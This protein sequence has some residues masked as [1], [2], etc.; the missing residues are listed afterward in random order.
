MMILSPVFH[1]E[2]GVAGRGV[3]LVAGHFGL[4]D[5]ADKR[6]LRLRRKLVFTQAT[7]VLGRT[8]VAW[9]AGTRWPT[10][11]IFAKPLD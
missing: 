9:V 7:P 3:K 2:N 1:V 5:L 6:V 11:G 10:C 4:P 8:G